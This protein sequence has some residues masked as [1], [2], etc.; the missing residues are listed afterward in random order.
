MSALNLRS[1]NSGAPFIG[2]AN[3]DTL[4]WSASERG[5][6]VG[7]AVG[8]VSSVFGRT[9]VVVA[10]TGDYDGDQVDNVSTVPGASLSDALE[11]LQAHAGAVTS[12]F[13]RT[14]VVV[15][16]T[17]DYDSDQV[18]NASS[19]SGA[20]VSDA[21]EALA[22]LIPTNATQLHMSASPRVA[23]RYAAGAGVVQEGVL[24]GGIEVT[25]GLDGFQVQTTGTARGNANVSPD[26]WPSLQQ[27]GALA[28]GASV[29]I[30]FPGAAT[31]TKSQDI[32]SRVWV[33]SNDG[34]GLLVFACCL[35]NVMHRTTGGVPTLIVH[36]QLQWQFTAV[37]IAYTSALVGNDLVFTLTNTSGTD[38]RYSSSTGQI[39]Q[40]KA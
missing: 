32:V 8:G 2:S 19:V 13:G 29:T 38:R 15:A 16:T 6:L 3:G 33:D 5:W 39:Q 17:G 12:V 37:G 18:D 31:T 27:K 36:D 14:G 22:A 40:D 25:A 1:S 4:L 7:A 11:Y 9:G 20:S 28:N 35:L 24:G 26:F 34:A 23:G 30:T 21:L 10:A